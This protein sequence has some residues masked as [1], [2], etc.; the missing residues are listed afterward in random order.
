MPAGRNNGEHNSTTFTVLSKEG[1][2]KPL[3]KRKLI[4]TAF[5]VLLT[6]IM[7]F[8]FY[9][10]LNYSLM[11]QIDILRYPPPLVPPELTFDGYRE[12]FRVVGAYI[13]TS[14][15]YGFGTAAVTMT[16]AAPAAYALSR[17]RSRISVM[18]MLVLLLAQMAPGI[19][20]VNSLYAMFSKVGILNSY[21]AVILA[22]STAAVPFAIISCVLSCSAFLKKCRKQLWSTAQAI[23]P[24]LQPSSY[25]SAVRP[26]SRL[27]YLRFLQAGETL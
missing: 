8:P 13:R 9:M 3:R 16:I 21:I 15:I 25:P 10:I 14:L 22:D 24:Y 6:A 11:D 5:G 26:L 27:H 1:S 23:G 2:S 18:L 4:L 7:L 19:V 17:I 20:V 12:A